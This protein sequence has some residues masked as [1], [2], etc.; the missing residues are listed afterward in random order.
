MIFKCKKCKQVYNSSYYQVTTFGDNGVC[1]RC[2]GQERSLNKNLKLYSSEI[3]NILPIS[4]T[5]KEF[6]VEFGNH[7]ATYRIKVIAEDKQQV[8][9]KIWDLVSEKFP[10]IDILTVR[11]I[12]IQ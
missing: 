1:L 8:R 12:K 6:L 5:S 3:Y 7:T 11:L 10:E 9:Y 4:E 2:L